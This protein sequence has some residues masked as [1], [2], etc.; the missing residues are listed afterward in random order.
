MRALLQRVTSAKVDVEG[1]TVGQIGC[2]MLAL[3]GVA[4]GDTQ[5]DA[6]WLCK[7]IVQLRIF[8]DENGVMNRSLMEIDGDLLAVSQ[9]TLCA[10]T[11]KG[12][13]PSY[14]AAARPEFA[15]PFFDAF[16]KQLAETLEKPVPTGVF[17]AMMQV[18]LVNDGPVT[19]W[20][21]SRNRE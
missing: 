5:E 16:V 2:G 12:N 7:K 19:L 11:R 8:D 20:L 10:S 17:G 21:D 13:R 4:E 15:Q 14:S 9:F 1:Q 6:D 18:S 3:I